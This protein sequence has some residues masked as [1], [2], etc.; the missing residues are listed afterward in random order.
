V[1]ALLTCFLGC[2]GVCAV[3]WPRSV[4]LVA[5][6]LVDRTIAGSLLV[7]PTCRLVGGW[8][9]GNKLLANSFAHVS[10]RPCNRVAYP[11]LPERTFSHSLHMQTQSL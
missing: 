10:A 3:S 11:P 5:Y 8:S 2:C 9:G 7:I 4:R 6:T 1:S